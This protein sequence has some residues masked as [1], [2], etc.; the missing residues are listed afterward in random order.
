MALPGRQWRHRPTIH[1]RLT[2]KA[3]RLE[4]RKAE[5][6]PQLVPLTAK[7]RALVDELQAIKETIDG[8]DRAKKASLLDT[9]LE[10]VYPVLDV[11]LVG[12]QK[13]RRTTVIR[14]DFDPKAGNPVL[15]NGM[16]VEV[17]RRGRGSW[18]PPARTGP[19]TSC[20]ASPG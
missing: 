12:P 1:Q 16:K 17:A 14:F 11:K 4:M 7:A 8:N 10:A 19:G 15:S 2:E 3:D 6:A 20:C 5:I 9:F 18:P 13:K